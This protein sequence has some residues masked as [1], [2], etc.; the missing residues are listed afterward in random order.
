MN[1]HRSDIAKARDNWLESAEGKRCLDGADSGEYL[2]NRLDRAYLAGVDA[3]IAIAKKRLAAVL[4]TNA[5]T[6][7]AQRERAS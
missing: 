5:A 3:G 4:D 7:A 2:R 1:D 6:D